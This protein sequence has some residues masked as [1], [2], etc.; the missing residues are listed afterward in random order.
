M[1]NSDIKVVSRS[2]KVQKNSHLFPEPAH[3]LNGLDFPGYSCSS[4]AT[5]VIQGLELLAN[6]LQIDDLIKSVWVQKNRITTSDIL[7]LNWTCV[8]SLRLE[9]R[10]KL[11]LIQRF[12]FY[13]VLRGNS[14]TQQE[15]SELVT[16][17]FIMGL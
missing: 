10:G 9:V 11:S 14:F 16:N 5:W 12:F 1:G 8:M 6:L 17:I 13:L 3:C 4:A 2:N 15:Y 7:T